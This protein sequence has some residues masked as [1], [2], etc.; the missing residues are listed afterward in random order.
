MVAWLVRSACRA[1]EGGAREPR[2]RTAAGGLAAG[3]CRGLGGRGRVQRAWRKRA[4]HVA[5]G[6]HARAARVA[7]RLRGS[8][9][10]RCG[11]GDPGVDQHGA[12][13]HRC[14]AFCAG[15]ARGRQPEQQ[16]EQRCGA[17]GSQ[18]V[19]ARGRPGVGGMWPCGIGAGQPAATGEHSAAACL[20]D[21]A[22]QH[23]LLLLLWLL[24][25]LRPGQCGRRPIWQ[26]EVA[27]VP[28]HAFITL[29][30]MLFHSL[31]CAVQLTGWI[32]EQKRCH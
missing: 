7:R 2:L 11:R 1:G 4:N 29:H 32:A 30:T 20:R 17:Q 15:G 18:Q 5:R 27:P 14:Q 12:V 16:V 10:G 26:H 31:A 6:R 9:R 3:G 8:G 22:P 28:V 21:D 13:A 25:V 19:P 23:A 24:G